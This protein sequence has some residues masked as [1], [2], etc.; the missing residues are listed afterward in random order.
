MTT[1][2]PGEIC[3]ETGVWTPSDNRNF[4]PSDYADRVMNR[5]F[6][7]GD[8]MPKIPHGEP[9]WILREEGRRIQNFAGLSPEEIAQKID[10]LIAPQAAG[11]PIRRD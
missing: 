10:D 4:Y 11:S 8:M 6:K 2:R 9:S 5:N 3:P 1:V 7:A